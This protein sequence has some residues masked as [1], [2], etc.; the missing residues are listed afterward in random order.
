VL[1]GYAF[2]GPGVYGNGD[3]YHSLLQRASSS[4]RPVSATRVWIHC[5]SLGHAS[6]PNFI[7]SWVA[8]ALDSAW[9]AVDKSLPLIGLRR[10]GRSSGFV[11]PQ[12]N[13][14]TRLPTGNWST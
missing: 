10:F 11:G 14:R 9:R 8:G 13:T 5:Q 2:L 1:G 4:L 6:D 3:V 7:N 12:P